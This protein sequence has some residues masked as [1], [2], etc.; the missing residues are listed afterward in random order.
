M[1]SGFHA[2]FQAAAADMHIECGV[3][4]SKA[5]ALSAPIDIGKG[6]EQFHLHLMLAIA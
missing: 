4:W 5:W 1:S 3:K 2:A 6:Y